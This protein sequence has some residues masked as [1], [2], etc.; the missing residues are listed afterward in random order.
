[1]FLILFILYICDTR[2]IFSVNRTNFISTQAFARS[3]TLASSGVR[4]NAHP[5]NKLELCWKILFLIN[6]YSFVE[7]VI[8]L[9]DVMML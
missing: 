2:S 8:N 5:T 9:N 7:V 1:M 6:L 4:K 3:P